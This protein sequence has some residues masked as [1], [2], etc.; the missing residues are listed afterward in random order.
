VVA[1]TAFV[2]VDRVM[3]GPL[4]D[5]PAGRLELGLANLTMLVLFFWWSMHF[6]QAG[7]RPW[8][9]LF[10]GAFA[11]GVF[12]IGLGVFASLY[13]PGT[14]GSDSRLYGPIGVIFSL[15]TWFIAI[16]AVIALGAVVGAS[17]EARRARRA[18]SS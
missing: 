18:S 2:I 11:T 3:S 1:V 8:R 9:E 14:I 15:V 6:L 4:R 17:W 13:F 16:G 12:W 10:V 5:E 7:R